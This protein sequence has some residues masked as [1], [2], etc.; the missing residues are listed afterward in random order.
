MK[1]LEDLESLKEKKGQLEAEVQKYRDSDPE[2][3][4]VLKKEIELSKQS[5]NRYLRMSQA[6]AKST[7]SKPFKITY[8]YFNSGGP[9]ISSAFT[10]GSKRSSLASTSTISTRISGYRMTLTTSND[11]PS[12]YSS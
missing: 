3:I 1:L 6:Y 12:S 4:E 9:K 11:L 5:A 10:H 7:N 2:L 8:P